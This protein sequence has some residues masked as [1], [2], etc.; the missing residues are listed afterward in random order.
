MVKFP[1]IDVDVELEYGESPVIHPG[2]S[3]TV[4]T[5]VTNV[6][7]ETLDVEAS[8]AIP[9]DWPVVDPQS[10]TLAPGET[11]ALTWTLGPVPR[12]SIEN[13]NRLRLDLALTD[14]PTPAPIP[15]V[16]IGAPAYRV[17]LLPHPGGDDL[18]ALEAAAVPEGSGLDRVGEWVDHSVEGNDVG[19]EALVDG[20]AVLHVQAFWWAPDAQHVRMG[21]DTSSVSRLV[22]N[23]EV[24]HTVDE[25]T[26]IRPSLNAS[27]G[28]TTG[29]DLQQGWNEVLLT[30]VR[31][32]EPLDGQLLLCTDDRMR[33]S[34][35]AIGRTRTLADQ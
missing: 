17:S 18:A 21:F 4:T 35:P 31:G 33:D 12:S 23:Q 14:R 22:L 2:T 34:L 15:F 9:Q 30:V 28:S 27:K 6:R 11:R 7:E 25:A 32:T 20:P 24:I 29:A 5:H 13:T 19:L 1:G 8:L 3:R 26:P 16:L 10:L